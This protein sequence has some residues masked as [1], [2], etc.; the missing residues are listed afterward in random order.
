MKL[1]GIIFIKLQ[2]MMNVLYY[3]YLFNVKFLPYTFSD[4]NTVWMLG[5]LFALIV[6]SSL[7]IGLAYFFG[8]TLGRFQVLSITILLVIF[9]HFKYNR[10]GKG[11]RIVKKKN[12]SFWVAIQLL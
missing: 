10:S 4:S 6:N 11:I 2:Q 5:S 8:Y 3:I 1:Y 12:L 7:N 9:F